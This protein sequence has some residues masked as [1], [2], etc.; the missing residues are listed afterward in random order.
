VLS[1]QASQGYYIF[2]ILSTLRL[3][4]ALCFS[5]RLASAIGFAAVAVHTFVVHPEGSGPYHQIYPLQVYTAYGIVLLTCG[6]I[7]A[8][9]S[10]QFRRQVMAALGGAA[11]RGQY[12]RLVN[13]IAYREQ[14]EQSLRASQRRYRQLTEGTREPIAIRPSGS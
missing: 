12:E 2:I 5:T 9:L 11:I 7:A 6:T 3:R 14:A 13:E 1:A 4:P 8:W 10:R